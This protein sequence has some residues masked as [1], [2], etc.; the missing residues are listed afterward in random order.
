MKT[1]RNL[2]TCHKRYID[3]SKHSD[4]ALRAG[5]H[6]QL[7]FD[8]PEPKYIEKLVFNVDSFVPFFVAVGRKGTPSVC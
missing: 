1:I 6:C 8:R 5:L 3:T 4:Y 7:A 2:I